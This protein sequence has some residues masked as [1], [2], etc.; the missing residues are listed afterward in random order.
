VRCHNNLDVATVA[1]HLEGVRTIGTD[2]RGRMARAAAAS[3]TTTA[4]ALMWWLPV[5]PAAAATTAT[6]DRLAQCETGGE[7]AANYGNDYFGG[8]QISMEFWQAYGGMEYAPRPDLASRPDQILVAQK[9]L[10]EASWK[11]WPVCS[12]RLH[13][14]N[15]EAMGTP[16]VTPGAR[17]TIESAGPPVDESTPPPNATPE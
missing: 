5:R 4:V 10:D 6:W 15:E 17:P 1:P 9:V 2:G 12:H 7:W 13:L 14:T 8:L 16:D 3:V 11:P